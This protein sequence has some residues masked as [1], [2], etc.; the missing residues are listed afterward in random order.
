MS[1][2]IE[3]KLEAAAED[4]ISI[5]ENPEANHLFTVKEY[6]GTFT[7]VQENLFQT[8][9]AK[10][11]FVSCWSRP[12]INIALAFLT[13]QVCNPNKDDRRKLACMILYIQATRGMDLTLEVDSMDII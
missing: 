3:G 5:D 7:R 1:K 4:M 9:V 8:L 13:T 2:N 6:G 10:I 11:S 12:E